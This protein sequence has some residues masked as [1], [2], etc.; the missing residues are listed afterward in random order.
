[1]DRQTKLKATN[2]QQ[3]LLQLWPVIFCLTVIQGCIQ[4]DQAG[5]CRRFKNGKFVLRLKP[6]NRRCIIT[7]S[8]TTQIQY[9]EKIDTVTVMKVKWTGPC[10]YELEAQYEGKEHESPHRIIRYVKP[11][12][13]TVKIIATGR[14]YYVFELRHDS[15]DFHYRDTMWVYNR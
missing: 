8:D 15:F 13:L 2:M 3:Q 10:E 5:D 9:D 1:M 6:D 12:P 14:N 7:R 11:E 4:K